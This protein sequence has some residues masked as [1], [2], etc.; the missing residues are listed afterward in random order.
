M[1]KFAKKII[2]MFL[3]ELMAKIQSDA[4]ETNGKVSKTWPGV[5]VNSPSSSTTM[6]WTS[7]FAFVAPVLQIPFR[8]VLVPLKK[9]VLK[10]FFVLKPWLVDYF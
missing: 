10:Y 7:S 6:M 1:K 3:K 9:Y 8:L 5:P 2:A 4:F